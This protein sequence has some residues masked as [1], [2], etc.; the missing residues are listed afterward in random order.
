MA[1]FFGWIPT[2]ALGVCWVSKAM[3]ADHPRA[4]G[5][6]PLASGAGIFIRTDR[7]LAPPTV[8]KAACPAVCNVA[9]RPVMTGA[10]LERRAGFPT[11]DMTV[12]HQTLDL[13]A[14]AGAFEMADNR[15]VF[16]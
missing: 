1:G 14:V 2:H 12:D 9:C 8:T 7:R 11:A 10:R 15:C 5:T 6:V 13:K 16:S 3:I 4:D